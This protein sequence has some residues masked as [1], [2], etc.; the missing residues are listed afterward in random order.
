[1]GMK[2]EEEVSEDV[3][4]EAIEEESAPASEE[5]IAEAVEVVEAEEVQQESPE[6]P[7]EDL[8][9]EKEE[10]VAFVGGAATTNEVAVEAVDL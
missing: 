7:V 10:M 1:M 6:A 4:E 9:A 3:V 5:E 2:D 8:S